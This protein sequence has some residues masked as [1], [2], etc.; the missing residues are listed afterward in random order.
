MRS[1]A[2]RLIA[3]SAIAL[4]LTLGAAPATA[5]VDWFGLSFGVGGFSFSLGYSDYPVY[6]NDWNDPS[7]SLD[8]DLALTGY[9]GW[10]WVDGLGRVWQPYVAAGWQPY[11]NGQWVWTAH[12]WTWV[13]YE[14]WG[15]VPHHYGAGP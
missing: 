12:G 7:W 15:Y 3:T 5:G 14:P 4:I 2:H 1:T 10:V 11:S 9:G 6:G 8:F 13:A